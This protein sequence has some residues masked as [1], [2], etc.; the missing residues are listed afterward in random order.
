M[1]LELNHLDK[2]L[3]KGVKILLNKGNAW[4]YEYINEPYKPLNVYT[5]DTDLDDLPIKAGHYKDQTIG[6]KMDS[7]KP[8][9]HPLSDLTKEITHN[10]E[11]FVPLVK[12]IRECHFVDPSTD[13]DFQVGG[14]THRRE[15]KVFYKDDNRIYWDVLV[16]I[17]GMRYEYVDKLLDYHFDTDNLIENNLAIDVNQI[18]ENVYG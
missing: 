6:L 17:E 10:G 18:K 13:L 12:M 2:R 11:K 15:Y 1:K 3:S 8:I 7:F 5:I 9:L 4:A 16:H 14:K